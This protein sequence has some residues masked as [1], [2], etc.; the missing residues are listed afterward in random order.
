[1]MQQPSLALTCHPGR[2]AISHY[3]IWSA[4]SAASAV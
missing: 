1:M 4:R 2:A 3:A